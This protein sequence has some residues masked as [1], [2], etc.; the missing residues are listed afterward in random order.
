MVVQPYCYSHTDLCTEDSLH[1]V[2]QH[3]DDLR[4]RCDRLYPPADMGQAGMDRAGIKAHPLVDAAHRLRPPLMH[5]CGEE[6]SV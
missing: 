1:R 5:Q 6:G 3:D 4:I 2:A